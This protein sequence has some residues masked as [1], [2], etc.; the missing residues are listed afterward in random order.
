MTEISG[1][2]IK[3][4]LSEDSISFYYRAVRE[5]GFSNP[6]TV[7]IRTP[8]RDDP[9]VKDRAKLQNEYEVTKD[10]DT[11]NVLK[12]LELFTQDSRLALIFE[13]FNATPLSNLIDS[14]NVALEHMLRVAIRLSDI[15]GELH[16]KKIIHKNIKPQNILIDTTTWQTKLTGFDIASLY[17]GE[18]ATQV[19]DTVEGTLAYMSPE[20]TGRMNR[21]IDYRS[22]LYALGTVFYEMLTGGPPFREEDPLALVHAQMARNPVP[23]HQ[24]SVEVPEVLSGIVMK[25]LSKAPEQRYQSTYGLGVD[26]KRCQ[27]ELQSS[28]K[29]TRFEPGEHDPSPLFETSQILYGR[30]TELD[31]LMETFSRTQNGEGVFAIIKGRSGIG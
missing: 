3:E 28:G 29:I 2:R 24:V 14:G 22:D 7:I 1:Y 9:D 6:A 26:L 15:L 19:A 12:P 18:S 31:A 10:L 25:L 17:S 21:V 8:K 23:P 13:D 30:G 27:S 16:G 4:K 20:Q 11:E 5:Q